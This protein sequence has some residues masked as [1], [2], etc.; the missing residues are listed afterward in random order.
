MVEDTVLPA[1]VVNIKETEAYQ[2]IKSKFTEK[3]CTVT[4][5]NPS[6]QFTAKQGSLWG[7]TP[8]TAKK[9]ITV[10]FQPTGD[11]TVIEYSSKLASDWK[12]I[13][14]IGCALAFVLSVVC[15]WMAL[16]LSVFLVNDNPSFWSWLVTVQGHI[17]KQAG[18]AFVNLAWGLAIFLSIIIALELA[19]YVYARS[20]IDLFAQSILSQ[21]S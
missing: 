1:Q 10:A 20:K 18:E 13:T 16:D 5:E 15:V 14:L 19:V 11:K 9:A 6:K 3:G 21:Y 17:E 2:K 4:A 7:I 8:Q 12:N